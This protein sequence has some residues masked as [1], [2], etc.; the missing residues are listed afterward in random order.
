MAGQAEKSRFVFQRVWVRLA[1]FYLILQELE[2]VLQRRLILVQQR[3]ALGDVV[4]ERPQPVTLSWIGFHY[5]DAF[6]IPFDLFDWIGI[7]N[8]EHMHRVN[9]I[10]RKLF[11]AGELV[12]FCKAHHCV[13]WF[14]R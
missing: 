14:L 8:R 13:L 4:V 5:L 6:Q 1:F 10:T 12:R 3:I 7:G 9:C 11:G 2:N